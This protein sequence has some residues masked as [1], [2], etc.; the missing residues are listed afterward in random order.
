PQ[1]GGISRIE[2][3]LDTPEQ[4]SGFGFTHDTAIF[5]EGP[6]SSAYILL[7]KMEEKM[8]AA[9]K[10]QSRIKAVDLKDSLER[11][12]ISHF[13]PDI[14]GN[15]RSFSRQNFRCTNCNAKYRRIPLKGECTKCNKGN[16]ILTIAHGS[17]TKYLEIAKKMISKYGLSNYLS[18]RIDLIDE[19]IKSVFTSQ[20]TEQKNLFEF[21]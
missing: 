12:L 3:K 21:A 5:D 1:I 15:A 10:L 16:I 8:D 11:V 2:Q 6:K 14:I 18:Q 17:V 9:A 7:Q 20:K 13:L 4:Y 19:E